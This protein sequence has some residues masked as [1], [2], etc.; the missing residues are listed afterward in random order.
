[1]IKEWWFGETLLVGKNEHKEVIERELVSLTPS[2]FLFPSVYKVCRTIHFI[3]FAVSF[4]ENHL[5]D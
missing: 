1:M 3:L 4:A 2:P 5:P